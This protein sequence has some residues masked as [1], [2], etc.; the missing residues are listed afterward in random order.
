MIWKRIQNVVVKEWE[1][2]FRSANSALLVTLLPLLITGQALLYIYLVLRFAGAD[3]LV[4]T[5]LQVGVHKFEALMPAMASLSTLD[6]FQVFFYLQ[7]P[8]YLLLIPAMI[9]NSMAT[10]GIVEEKQ[11]RTLEPL[12]ATPVRT[13]EL[14]FGKAL[15][16]AIPAVVMSWVCAGLFLI[17]V[18][19]LG[20]SHLLRFVLTSSWFISLLLLVPG[21]TVLSFLLGVIASSRAKDA[22]GAQNLAVVIVLPILGLVVVQLV[23]LAVFTPLL[24]LLV[25]AAIVAL[26]AVTLRGAVRLFQRESIL[27]NWK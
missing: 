3:A 14:L 4:N 24:L 23:G 22:K 19:L 10:F 12:L 15:A 8:V 25:A 5:V 21:V 7:F 18:V 13:W 2:T 20:S 17:G 6:Q 11:T 27:V 26:D 9:A 1:T 16:G